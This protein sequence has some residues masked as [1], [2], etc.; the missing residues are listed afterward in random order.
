VV[1]KD[2]P[3][4]FDGI[5]T[6][7]A[8]NSVTIHTQVDGVLEKVAFEEGQ[9]VNAGDLLATID[10]RSY[11]AQLDQAKAKKAADE[12]QLAS[13][14]VIYLRNHT[15]LSKGLI[16][17]QTVDTQKATVDQ[18][19]ASVQADAA[20]VEQQAVQLGYTQIKAPISGRTGVRLVDSG[21]VV[22]SSDPTGLVVITQLKPVSVVF[23][24]PQ[25]D[26]PLL[27]PRLV[28][29]ARLKVLAMGQGG[30]EPL[31]VGELRV[32]DNQIDAT[33]G[34]LKLKAAFQNAQLILWPGQFVNVRLLVQ[35]RTRGIVVPAS[36]I[37]RGPQGAYAFV[38]KRDSTVEARPVQVAQI[39]EGMALIDQGLNP[40][41]EV[42]V[43]GQY[44]LQVGS[45]V[46]IAPV[47]AP[48][49]KSGSPAPPASS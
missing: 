46:K 43:D 16:D 32:V 6:V 1:E 18:L 5:G 14:R 34:T 13:A 37:Q 7:Q 9:D 49:G 31:D 4:Y 8:Y 41:E 36:V 38:I 45:L 26:W 17:Q 30:G 10:P 47:A 11:Q 20:A 23:T 15:L 3:I 22:H 35:T 19:N 33:T 44:K 39:D 27:Q 28:G 12:V 21:N 48:G 25:Q 2:T 29:R 40:G 24:L 42:V